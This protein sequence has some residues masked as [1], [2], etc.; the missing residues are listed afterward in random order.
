[1]KRKIYVVFTILGIVLF[2]SSCSKKILPLGEKYFTVSPNP[3]EVKGEKVEAEIN[4]VIPQKYF[5]KDAILTITP[6]LKYHNKS[7]GA[8]ALVFQ[9][10][11]LV[12]NYTVVPYKTGKNITIPVSFVFNP[13]MAHSELFLNF[14][15]K[16]SNKSYQLPSVKVAEGINTVSQLYSTSLDELPPAIASNSFKKVTKEVQEADIL[17]LIQQAR[18]RKSELNKQS[19]LD[20]EKKLMQ[21]RYS[22]DKKIKEIEVLGY[23]SPDGSIDINQQL[24]QKRQDVT[25]EYINKELKKLK[26]EVNIDTQFTAEDWEGFQKLLKNSDVQDKELILRVLSMYDDPEER[27]REIKN[28]SA[29][30]QEV[31]DEIL[32]QLR[33]SRLK[34]KV[35]V[36]GKSDNEIRL[37]SVQDPNSLTKEELLYAGTLMQSDRFK[38]EIYLKF[39]ERFPKDTRGYINY[40]VVRYELNE[41]NFAEKYFQK[42]LKIDVNDPNA[43]FN[44]GLLMLKKGQF[45]RA[46]EYFGK[47]SQSTG[48]LITALGTTYIAK[49]NYKRAEKMFSKIN[50]NNA[51]LT[52][53]LNKNYNKAKKTI[54]AIQKPNALTYYLSAIIAARTN[55][56]DELYKSLSEVGQRNKILFQKALVE[57]EFSEY[58][59][60][61]DFKMSLQ[62]EVNY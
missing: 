11:D 22:F 8:K 44:M 55:N 29:T 58:L 40:G 52:A 36:M 21:A 5:R 32:P 28:L 56:R 24:A 10:E 12:D 48:N 17:F 18:L 6:I 41:F 25:R 43:N 2:V 57:F 46:E 27:E 35:D 14:S 1:M 62:K 53:I 37:A 20:F 59:K 47:A 50:S 34:L 3:L 16:Q 15:V 60:N 61:R 54:E 23:A 42:A 7:L 4:G 9:G 19:V 38:S 26:T 45:N 51:V 49:G 31:A 13:E 30:F 33:R 39:I